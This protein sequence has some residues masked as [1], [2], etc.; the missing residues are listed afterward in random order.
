[1][2]KK[3]KVSKKQELSNCDYVTL[4]VTPYQLCPKCN[5]QGI[6]SKPSYVPGDVHEWNST[7]SSFMCDVCWGSKIIPMYVLSQKVI[8]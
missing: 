4:E 1:M 5:G 6:V 8:K 3:I 2:N 7:S